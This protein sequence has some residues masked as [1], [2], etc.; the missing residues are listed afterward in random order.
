ML[1]LN[2][3]IDHTILIPECTQF[4]VER[5]CKE[6]LEHNFATVFVNPCWVSLAAKLLKGSHTK[7]GSVAGFP[8]G[9]STTDQKIR[10]AEENIKNGAVETDMVMNVGIFRQKDFAYVEKEIRAV[11]KVCLP[12]LD[13]KVIIEAG[14]LTDQEKKTA[15]DLV[16]KSGA[17]FV[18]TSTGFGSGGAKIEDV[19]LLRKAVGADFGVKASGG[20]RDCRFALK[21]LEAGANRIGSSVS[22]QIMQEYKR[23]QT[24]EVKK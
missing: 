22:V 3:V 17:D 8:L 18:K 1:E 23:L 6:A 11:R 4:D 5:I 9:A 15:A 21:L 14:L 12:P 24:L 16:K 10:E 19:I 7:V 2:R 20:I 13:L